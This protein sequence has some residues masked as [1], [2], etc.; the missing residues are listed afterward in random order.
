MSIHYIFPILQSISKYN[1]IM[2]DIF[3]LIIIIKFQYCHYVARRFL[4]CLT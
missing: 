4:R 3:N 2:N 1:Y